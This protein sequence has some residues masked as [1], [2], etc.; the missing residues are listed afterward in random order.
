MKMRPARFRSKVAFIE[1]NLEQTAQGG[2][3]VT[4]NA[5]L[6]AWANVVPATGSERFIAEQMRTLVDYIITTRLDLSVKAKHR[7]VLPAG[8]ILD[9]QAVLAGDNDPLM[10]KV[11]AGS[12]REAQQAAEAAPMS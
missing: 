9:V 4:D 5:Y 7:V 6:I 12:R 8:Q 10:M 3:Q 2:A 1:E 11:L